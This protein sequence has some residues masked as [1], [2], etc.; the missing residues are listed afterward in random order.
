M[1]PDLLDGLVHH[2]TS[3]RESGRL[4]GYGVHRLVSLAA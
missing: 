1:N 2:G 4:C 3:P